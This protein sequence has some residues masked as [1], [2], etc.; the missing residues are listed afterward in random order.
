VGAS[1]SS[2]DL[3]GGSPRNGSSGSPGAGAAGV[4]LGLG[5]GPLAAAGS[6]RPDSRSASRGGG[7][8]GGGGVSARGGSGNGG[9]GGVNRGSSS[10]SN[11]NSGPPVG[12][13]GMDP[14]PGSS[15]AF[16][17]QKVKLFPL[18]NANATANGPNNGTNSGGG[19]GN[20]ATKADAFRPKAF[21]SNDDDHE[22]DNDDDEFPPSPLPAEI[23]A[24]P[25]TMATLSRSLSVEIAPYHTEVVTNI[26]KYPLLVALLT[27]STS[28]STSG[29]HGH[30]HTHS[31]TLS[32]NAATSK[33]P[34][35]RLV[36]KVYDVMACRDCVINVNIKEFVS[37]AAELDGKHDKLASAHY[38]PTDRTWWATHIKDLIR[39]QLKRNGQLHMSISKKSIENIVTAAIKKAAAEDAS[40]GIPR[41][42]PRKSGIDFTKRNS[43]MAGARRSTTMTPAAAASSAGGGGGGGAKKASVAGGGAGSPPRNIPGAAGA[44]A[45]AGAVGGSAKKPAARST[46]VAHSVVTGRA[47]A[48]G[49]LGTTLTIRNEAPTNNATSNGN[50]NGND[51]SARSENQ[52]SGNNSGGDDYDDNYDEAFD[53][54]AVVGAA[55]KS[56][57][58]ASSLE[59][60]DYDQDFEG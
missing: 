46:M 2:F 38:H 25:V 22:Y 33:E 9:R 35:E 21:D 43:V 55:E 6:M 36:V 53:G 11:S 13:T 57:V 31:H 14:P 59:G 19:G 3:S 32:S 56:V 27:H 51:N 50:D 10:N 58:L 15:N 18:E 24:K 49:D 37:Y 1:R 48:V 39:V 23:R 60:E 7:T 20:T 41:R 16:V 52:R 29:H 42:I 34:I 5:V 30:S 40:R 8:G 12:L 44:G 28:T 47:S 4:G 54:D 17:S 26:Y 45:G